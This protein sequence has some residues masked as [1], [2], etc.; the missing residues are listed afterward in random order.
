MQKLLDGPIVGGDLIRLIAAYNGGP[1]PVKDAL[2]QLGPDSNDSILLMESIPVAETREY[3]EEVA[4]NYW[5]YHQILGEPN[6][7]LAQA[8]ADTQVLVSGPAPAASAT[9]TLADAED[10][11][12]GPG[13]AN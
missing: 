5:I 8:A 1:G 9:K 2:G 13:A 6:K 3:V 11:R 12:G 7:T 10:G 4:A